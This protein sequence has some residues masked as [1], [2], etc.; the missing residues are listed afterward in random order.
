MAAIRITKAFLETKLA[1]MESKNDALVAENNKLRAQLDE[2]RTAAKQ[3]MLDRSSISSIKDKLRRC[4]ELNEQGVPCY[5]KD[6]IIRHQ[7]TKAV[8]R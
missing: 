7:Y 4:R 2:Y 8:L 3:D 1:A 5:V 6:G